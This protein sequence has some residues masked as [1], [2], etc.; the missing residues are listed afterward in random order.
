MEQGYDCSRIK[1]ED[2]L[3]A[4]HDDILITDGDG[5]ILRLSKS[6]ETMYGVKTE[7]VFGKTVYQLE[8]EGVFRPS[9]TA[10]VLKNGEKTTM[11]QKNQSGRDIV[12]TAV[13]VRNEND[14]IVNVISFSRDVTDYL[15]LKE[16]YNELE[17]RLAKYSAEINELRGQINSKSEIIAKS[18]EMKKAI[19]L[20]L[21]VAKHDA[22]VL[23]TGE[24]G[25]G[26]TLL[27]RFIHANSPRAKEAFVEINCGAIPATLIES[28]LFGYE[29]GS[30]TG[31]N[32]QGKVGLVEIAHKGTLFL[33]EISEL[34][35]Q[36]QT[37]LLKLV[38]DK[39]FVKVGGTKEQE[40]DFCLITATNKSLEEEMRSG[41]FRED[42]YYRVNVINIHI[43][44]LRDRQE[45]MIELIQHFLRRFNEKHQ[46]SKHLSA[47]AYER[48]LSHEWPGNIREL[49]NM[50]ERM[51]IVSETEEIGEDSLPLSMTE[52]GIESK[53]SSKIFAESL[54]IF[55]K[56]QIVEAYNKYKT[57]I[58]VAK[59]LGI[60]QPTA[61]RKIKKF[62]PDA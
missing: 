62:I 21:K 17:I 32:R 13:P 22:S 47:K 16:Q 38:Q 49:Q 42:L 48:L 6:F 55:E 58:G 2:I 40:I 27:A 31:A 35:L 26:K 54:H 51:I 24:S 3:D 8:Q 20:G 53:E 18:S 23:L 45:D 37:K 12:V 29:P 44:P 52:Y 57:S 14:E 41:R 56:D 46:D 11:C 9:I 1:L 5:V 28:E 19:K 43:P 59:A 15:A 50:I 61:Y 33:D 34:P 36:M 25:V 39:S 30:F 60:S 7:D 10:I 4:I